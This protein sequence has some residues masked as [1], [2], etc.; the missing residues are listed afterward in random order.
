MGCTTMLNERPLF[1][2]LA[3]ARSR[4]LLLRHTPDYLIF[5]GHVHDVL[6]LELQ[7]RAVK[8]LG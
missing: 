5:F 3:F 2:P 6:E 1:K 7:P 8:L 4:G